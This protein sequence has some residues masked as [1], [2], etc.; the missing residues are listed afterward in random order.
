MAIT[1]CKGRPG[2]GT[3]GF[4]VIIGYPGVCSG[5]VNALRLTP[6]ADVGIVLFHKSHKVVKVVALVPPHAVLD[7]P[8]QDAEA[9]FLLGSGYLGD[10]DIVN[11]DAH[12]G[13]GSGYAAEI[14]RGGIRCAQ[15]GHFHPMPGLGRRGGTGGS[16]DI[17]IEY[18]LGIGRLVLIGLGIRRYTVNGAGIE[19]AA[20]MNLELDAFGVAGL[21][22]YLE[23]ELYVA[24]ALHILEE[25]RLHYAA[26]GFCRAERQYALVFLAAIEDNPVVEVAAGEVGVREHMGSGHGGILHVVPGV[27]LH[28]AGSGHIISNF[29]ISTG[30]TVTGAPTGCAD[31][32]CIRSIAEAAATAHDIAA[33]YEVV[34]AL[35]EEYIFVGLPGHIRS[36]NTTCGNLSGRQGLVHHQM[37]VRDSSQLQPT[38]IGSGS[39]ED[40]NLGT[41][42]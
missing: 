19:M 12:R 15:D 33:P 17:V 26:L 4:A 10:R 7:V 16:N 37:I 38:G 41:R 2:A 29:S 13:T 5:Q 39:N 42:T 8:V 9:S 40:R 6:D 31:G 23:A 30:I 3:H 21:Q 1:A 22:A 18:G 35:E 25:G 14:H 27:G 28:V 11:P 24:G 36:I 34:E 20:V 32:R